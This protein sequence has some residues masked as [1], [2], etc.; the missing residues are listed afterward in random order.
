MRRLDFYDWLAVAG[1]AGVAF[2]LFM[3]FRSK[4]ANTLPVPGPTPGPVPVTPRPC[5]PEGQRIALIGDSHAEGLH[6]HMKAL[7]AACGTPYVGAPKRGTGALYWSKA[8]LLDQVLASHPTAVIISNGGNDYQL[9]SSQAP[10][11][12]A[13][14][15]KIVGKIRAAGARPIWVRST[16]LPW[17]DSPGIDAMWQQAVGSDWYNSAKFDDLPAP[18]KIHHYPSGYKLWAGDVWQTVGGML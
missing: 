8:F 11:L 5:P 1:T 4:P 10:A 3:H 16:R 9:S 14:V 6:P 7:A 13:A 17:P 18:D 15:T 2:A 12:Q